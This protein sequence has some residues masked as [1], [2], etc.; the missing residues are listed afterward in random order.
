MTE[1]MATITYTSLVS[2]ETVRIALMVSVLNDLKFKLGDIL[3]NY[4]QALITEKVWTSLDPEFGKNARKTAVI[5][6]AL[7]G[8]KSGGAAFKSHLAKCMES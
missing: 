6:R 1:A 8:L 7:H 5:I 3:N 2:R 4:A